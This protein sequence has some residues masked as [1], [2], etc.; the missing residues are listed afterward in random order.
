MAL[1]ACVTFKALFHDSA[2]HS[3]WCHFSRFFCRCCCSFGDCQ[4]IRPPLVVYMWLNS[5]VVKLW[6]IRVCTTHSRW[7]MMC[8]C[9]HG[10]AFG[11]H[12]GQP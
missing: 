11:Y 2:S 4:I 9:H 10:N 5:N 1:A 12:C 7:T 8:R 3:L 6:V